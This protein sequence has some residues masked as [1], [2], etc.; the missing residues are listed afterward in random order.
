MWCGAK[1]FVRGTMSLAVATKE[2]EEIIYDILKDIPKFQKG[3]KTA[4][5]RV[6]TAT[7]RLAKL[8]KEWRKLS[9]ASEKKPIKS[10]RS[11]KKKIRVVKARKKR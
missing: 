5:Q 7:I 11:S 2:I 3:N 8:S 6:R 4:A 9:L 1:R 10:K